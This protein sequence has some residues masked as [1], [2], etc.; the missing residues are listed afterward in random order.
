MLIATWYETDG[1]GGVMGKTGR[2]GLSRQKERVV[3]PKPSGEEGEL[4]LEKAKARELR[5]SEWWK[6]QL[7]KGVCHYCGG[8]FPARELTMD[9]V[10]PLSRGG[11][12]ARGNVVPCCKECNTRKKHLLPM[13]WEEWLAGRG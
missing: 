13:E 10:V 8:A 6:R 4:A 9:H 7:A 5:Q 11:R 1:R 12:T 2:K 3:V